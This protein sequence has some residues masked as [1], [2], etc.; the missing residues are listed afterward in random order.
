MISLRRF[1]SKE[2]NIYPIDLRSRQA[3]EETVCCFR[4][5]IN[6]RKGNM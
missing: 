1:Q 4:L 6:F 2:K 3:A 5:K